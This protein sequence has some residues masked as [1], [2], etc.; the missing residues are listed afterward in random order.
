MGVPQLSTEPLSTSAGRIEALP[1]PSRYTV[2]FC[3]AAEGEMV[4]NTVTTAVAVEVLLFTSVAVS[5]TLLAPIFAHVN[6]EILTE[7]VVGPQLSVD[8]LSIFAGVI[9]ALPEPSK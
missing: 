3:A 2:I 8:P 1:V 5:V 4:S 7:R 9:I 6:E